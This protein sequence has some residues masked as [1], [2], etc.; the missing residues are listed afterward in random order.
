MFHEF[1][2]N[3]E[4]FRQ[5]SNTDFP[6]SCCLKFLIIH[7]LSIQV[8]FCGTMLPGNKTKNDNSPQKSKYKY[9]EDSSDI[10]F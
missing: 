10:R 1:F 9:F 5:T 4:I 6:L 2:D 8:N 7:K 3:M